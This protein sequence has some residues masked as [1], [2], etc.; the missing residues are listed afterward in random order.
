MTAATRTAAGRLT[1]RRCAHP[2]GWSRSLGVER[3]P[4]CGTERHT[5][6]ATLR[7]PLPDRAPGPAYNWGCP[8][9]GAPGAR[10][11]PGP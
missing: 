5:A 6:Y 10:S 3:C 11:A 1:A 8:R 9:L 4:L 7:M 2:A